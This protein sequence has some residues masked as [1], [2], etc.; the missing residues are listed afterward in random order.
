MVAWLPGSLA[1]EEAHYIESELEETLRRDL[2]ELTAVVVSAGGDSAHS[3]LKDKSGKGFL[4]AANDAGEGVL[5]E[6][7]SVV[8]RLSTLGAYVVGGQRPPGFD[9]WPDVKK[10]VIGM[11]DG[12]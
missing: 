5:R 1:R 10:L 11:V 8:L 12:R 6:G 4:G 7:T 2:P 3:L 9:R